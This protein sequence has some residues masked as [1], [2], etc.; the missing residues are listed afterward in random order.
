M[1]FYGITYAEYEAE[2]EALVACLQEQGAVGLYYHN[3][4]GASTATTIDGK[5]RAVAAAVKHVGL[6]FIF[7]TQYVPPTPD[8]VKGM[9]EL[10]P[11]LS[12]GNDKYGEWNGS[13]ELA[14]RYLD[15]ADRE[16]YEWV[17]PIIHPRIVWDLA[18]GGS[19]RYMLAATQCFC[20]TGYMLSGYLYAD[21]RLPCPE[22]GRMNVENLHEKYGLTIES[23]HAYLEPMNVYCGAGFQEGLNA[24]SHI[25][26]ERLG[27]KGM[28]AGVPFE[29]P[30]EVKVNEKPDQYPA[31][32]GGYDT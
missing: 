6:D 20:L 13:A 26:A 15:D 2:P 9:M 23:L 3:L 24:G 5:A 22:T 1:K 17:C 28:V 7:G 19:L 18:S 30:K 16:G 12:L 29:I 8:V 32:T 14:A 10:S 31:K 21:A 4:R 25:Y 27:F 11:K